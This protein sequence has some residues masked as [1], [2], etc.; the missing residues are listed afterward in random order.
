MRHVQSLSS[1]AT[2]AAALLAAAAAAA[3]FAATARTAAAG[4]VTCSGTLPA[5]IYKDVSVPSGATCTIGTGVVILHDLTVQQGA[6]L[7]AA[8]A[9]IGHDLSANQPA[10]VGI[11]RSLVGH[12][13]SVDGT[14][15]AGPGPDGDNYVCGTTVGHDLTVQNSALGAGAWFL[16]AA[17]CGGPNTVGHDTSAQNNTTA[18]VGPGQSSAYVAGGLLAEAQANPAQSFNVIIEGAGAHGSDGVQNA[19][20][21]LPK[22][23]AFGFRQKLASID[24]GAAQVTGAQLLA[25]STTPGILAITSDAPVQLAGGVTFSNAQQWPFA[26]GVAAGWPAAGNGTLP[27]PPAIAIVDSGIDSKLGDFGNRIVDQVDLSTLPDGSHGNSTHGD[28]YGHGSFVAGIAAG[29]APGYAGAAPTAP[30]VSIDVM[31][32][33]GEALTS[34][35]IAACDWIIANKAR[36]NIRVANFSLTSAS[37]GSVF[38]DPLDKA[39][40]SLWF[41][42]VTVVAAAGNYAS[43]GQESGV[44]YAPANDPF[45]ITVGADDLHGTVSPADDAAAPW[46]AWGYTLD[47]FAK[48]EI[49]APGR[50]MIGPVP[51][52]STLA[53]ERPDSMVGKND[54]QLSGTSFAAPVVSG[55]AAYL[56]ALHPSW[57]PDQV[58]GALM[59]SA[60]ATP[61]ATPRSE[62]VGLVDLATAANVSNPPNPNRA[63]D[64]F[65]VPDP[66]GGPIPVFNATG[67]WNA[68]RTNASW[69]D[70]SWSGVSWSGVSWSGVSWSGA[71]WGTV[72]WSGVSWSGVSWSDNAQDDSGSAAFLDPSQIAV[73]EAE[74]GIAI[75]PDGSVS[76]GP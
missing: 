14:T 15:G 3:F 13:L 19:V 43:N 6:T 5:G 70:V 39:V 37:P 8:G 62:G 65:L 64:Q 33:Q 11:A 20:L 41:D 36:D 67:W 56:L 1:R 69:D 52:H 34:D 59:V 48:P 27:T 57:T 30:L 4:G 49:A 10:G 31:N 76:A 24:G 60:Q 74:L 53:T 50:Y 9:S 2:G 51:A 63:L 68:A 46:S 28:T 16:G 26:S 17:V 40:E 38:W 32:D 72:S 73:A 42:G 47:G 22:G 54:I 55:A 35:V 25:L 7:V 23:N 44:P 75:G 18:V 29:S 58:K 61:A 21:H 12:D 45:V 71:S 66:Q